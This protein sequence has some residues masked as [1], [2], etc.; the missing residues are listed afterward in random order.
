MTHGDTCPKY[1]VPG[2]RVDAFDLELAEMV[3]KGRIKAG[4]PAVLTPPPCKP[5]KLSDEELRQ[6][7]KRAAVVGDAL[8]KG[9]PVPL[10]SPP[11]LDLEL[12]EKIRTGRGAPATFRTTPPDF[13]EME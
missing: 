10:A 1:P 4:G 9:K 13:E 7:S 2:A 12:A 3:R 6:R 5:R 11:P 8:R